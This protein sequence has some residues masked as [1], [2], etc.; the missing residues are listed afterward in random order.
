MKV[1]AILLIAAVSVL[2]KADTVTVIKCDTIIAC[3]VLNVVTT[4]KDTTVV[5]KIDTIEV[6]DPVKPIKKEETVAS[7]KEKSKK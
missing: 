4:T 5:S 3:K 2:A 7:K 6:K 1:F